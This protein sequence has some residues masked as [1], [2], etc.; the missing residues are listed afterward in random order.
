M[1]AMALAAV[2]LANERQQTVLGDVELGGQS[3]NLCFEIAVGKS[4]RIDVRHCGR[5]PYL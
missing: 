2:E 1:V 4:A 3:S 5:V